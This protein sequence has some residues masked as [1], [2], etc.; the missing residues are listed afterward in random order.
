MSKLELG[1]KYVSFYHLLKLKNSYKK[2]FEVFFKI[3]FVEN[4]NTYLLR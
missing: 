3:I 1:P 2:N 4:A